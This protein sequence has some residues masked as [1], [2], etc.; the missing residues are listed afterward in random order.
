M[1]NGNIVEIIVTGKT[2]TV[3]TPRTS[4]CEF[5]GHE[6]IYLQPAQTNEF[7]EIDPDQ[8]TYKLTPFGGKKQKAPAS[9]FACNSITGKAGLNKYFKETRANEYI[10]TTYN[11]KTEEENFET[12]GKIDE[13]TNNTSDKSESE[14]RQN[15]NP[16]RIEQELDEILNKPETRKEVDTQDDLDNYDKTNTKMIISTTMCKTLRIYTLPVSVIQSG[17]IPDL[18]CDTIC[19]VLMQYGLA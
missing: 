15:I 1:S 11:D 4:T 14:E 7:H 2:V 8:P 6:L 3:R 9:S 16:Q 18:M 13:I 12:Y 19:N 5:S 17:Y 10:L